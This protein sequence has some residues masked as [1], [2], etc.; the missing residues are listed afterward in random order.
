[1]PDDYRDRSD[2]WLALHEGAVEFLNRRLLIKTLELD[3]PVSHQINE[4]IQARDK[5][6][7][8]VSEQLR[9][10]YEKI[11]PYPTAYLYVND[12]VN[13]FG[14]EFLTKEGHDQ[15]WN[16]IQEH[17]KYNSVGE[18]SLIN[19]SGLWVEIL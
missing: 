2:Q 18:P 6:T 13:R 5:T 15:I 7:E 8:L 1:M 14:E 3:H 9:N 4:E 16:I 19:T 12:L 17:Q 11:S 10:Q